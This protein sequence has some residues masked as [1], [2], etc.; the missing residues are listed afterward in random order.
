[1]FTPFKII[2]PL[3][4]QRN[5]WICFSKSAW[6]LAPATCPNIN[7]SLGVLQLSFRFPLT[8][9]LTLWKTTM[10]LRNPQTPLETCATSFWMRRKDNCI[11]PWS[12][13]TCSPRRRLMLVC[14]WKSHKQSKVA[15]EDDRPL[16]DV[17]CCVKTNASLQGL[18]KGKSVVSDRRRLRV[19]TKKLALLNVVANQNSIMKT[20][21]HSKRKWNLESYH[22]YWTSSTWS[23]VN[24]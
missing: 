18:K 11:H 6:E 8:R 9:H 20:H 4:H 17:A 13:C 2:C 21:K 12:F 22:R 3:S 5:G 7:F 14:F 19:D 24:D 16:I 23:H 10:M 1:M 15:A